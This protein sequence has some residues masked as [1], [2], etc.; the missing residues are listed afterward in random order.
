MEFEM[1]NQCNLECIM[2][3]GYVSSSIRQNRDKLPPVHSPYDE[4]FVTQLRPFIPHLRE[5]K[6][7]GGEP[8]LIPLYFKMWDAMMEINPSINIF[9]ITNGTVL[10]D[11]VKTLLSLGNFELAVSIDSIRKDRYEAGACVIV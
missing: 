4:K 5:A 8:F 3:N 1:S 10:T 7:F 6:F 2:C 11:K 9:V